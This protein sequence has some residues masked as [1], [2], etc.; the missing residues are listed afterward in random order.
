MLMGKKNVTI[1][2]EAEK[3]YEASIQIFHDAKSKI[4]KANVSL[5]ETIEDID[6][7]VAE[8]EALKVRAQKDKERNDKMSAKLEDFLKV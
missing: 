3:Q 5:L 4:D 2:E 6:K 1:I 7:K 8:L